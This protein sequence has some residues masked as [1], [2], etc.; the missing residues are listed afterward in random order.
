MRKTRATLLTAVAA[1][2]VT[3]LVYA[4]DKAVYPIVLW[5]AQ[6]IATNAA[7]RNIELDAYKPSGYFSVQLDVASGTGA[8]SA[9]TCEVSNNGTDYCQVPVTL[10]AAGTVVTNILSSVSTNSGPATNGVV[11][12]SFG[13]PI[14]RF[15]RLRCAVTGGTETVSGWLVIQ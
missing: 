7:S 14:A 15:L 10:G 9:V 13:P 11:F 6:S 5:D 12:T 8:V 4:G 3:V 2:A 1:A